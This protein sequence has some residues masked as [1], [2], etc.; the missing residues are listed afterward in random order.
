MNATFR[1]RAAFLAWVDV[2]EAEREVMA[3]G[4]SHLG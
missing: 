4:P 2:D 3:N 1:R